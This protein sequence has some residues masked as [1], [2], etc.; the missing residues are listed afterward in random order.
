MNKGLEDTQMVNEYIESFNLLSH[1]L[2]K[3]Q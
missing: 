2:L 1:I 3:S